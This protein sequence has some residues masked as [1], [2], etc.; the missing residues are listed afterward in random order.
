MWILLLTPFALIALC[1]LLA[2][3]ALAREASGTG[4]DAVALGA[5]AVA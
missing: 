3:V 1:Q 4:L 2:L 5:P